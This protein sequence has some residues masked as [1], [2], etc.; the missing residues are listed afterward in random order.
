MSNHKHGHASSGAKRS[1]EYR[2]YHHM[3][4][5]CTNPNVNDYDRYGGRGIKVCDRW[6]RSFQIF[7]SDIGLA[8]SSAH[9]LDRIDYDGDYEPLNCRWATPKEQANNRSLRCD[10]LMVGKI[11]LIDYCRQNNLN[12]NTIK[13]RVYKRGMSIDEAIQ[14]PVQKKTSKGAKALL[15]I[16]Q[17]IYP[18]H[19]IELEY[20][21]AERGALFVDI[22][23]PRLQI[24]FEYDGVQ[25]FEYNEHFHGSREHFIKARRRDNE[26]DEACEDK[27]IV[28]IRVAYNEDMDRNLVVSKIEEALNG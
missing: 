14:L 16:V 18:N 12:Y 19:R 7:L 24:G 8:P 1:K 15:E 4:Q 20:N 27:G 5:R 17:Q 25:H 2:A 13:G 3:I 21:V 9:S 23:L 26:K 22:Y 11:S 10:A 28:L 6:M